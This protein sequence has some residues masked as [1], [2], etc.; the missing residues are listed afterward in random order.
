MKNPLY[1]VC[2]TVMALLYG[3][4]HTKAAAPQ[5]VAGGEYYLYNIHYDRILGQ[6][7]DGT[8]PGLS[9]A[10][11]NSA[12]DSYV[13][14]AETSGTSGYF[15]LRQKSSGKYLAASTANTWS[16]LLQSTRATTDPYLW[17]IIP[18]MDGNL[19]C[20]KAST[21][22]LGCDTG[23]DADAYI[24]VFY[25]KALNEQSRWEVF[26]ANGS[27]DN[28]RKQ[29][30]LEE[31]SRSIA[32]GTLMAQQ[33]TYTE[34]WRQQVSA[35]VTAAEEVYNNAASRT[36][37]QI[38][39]ATSTLRKV[40]ME[41]R[42]SDA[43]TLLSGTNFDVDNSFT[44]ALNGL[45]QKGNN[46][47]ISVLIRNA[48]GMGA[49]IEIDGS[50]GVNIEGKVIAEPTDVEMI[51]HNDY[52]FA[53]NGTTVQIYRDGAL[54]GSAPSY[55]VPAYTANGTGAEW[56]IL[57]ASALNKY[58]P[59]IVSATK[60]VAQG[61]AVTDKYG[62]KTRYAIFLKDQ[63]LE[64]TEAVDFHLMQEATPL[65]NSTINLA[66]ENA[67]LIFDNTLPSVVVNTYL[68]SIKVNG[69][70]AVAGTNVHVGM[71]L[72][73]AIVMPQNSSTIPFTGY[74]GE[75]Y[76]GEATNLKLGANE[77]GKA[78]NSFRSFILKRGYMAVLAS[79]SNGSGYSRVYV[80]DHQDIKV[81]VL[82]QALNQRVSSVHIKK[83][84]YVSKKGWCSDKSSTAAILTDSKAVRA[85]WYY[86]WSADRYSTYDM[87]YIPIKQHL[88]WP[89]QSQ[90]T[91]QTASTHVLGYNEPEHAE[92]HTSSKCSCGGVIS[93]WT[94]CTK[95]PDLQ[96]TGMRIGS[97][98]PTD[99]SWLTQYIGH[100]NDMAYRCDFVVM[101]CYWGTNEAANA[102][103]WY[104]QLKT[105]YN[106]TKRP[107][108][109]T[110]WN[111]GASWTTESWPSSYGD[112]LE[113]NRAAI[114]EIL[115]VLDTCR[116]VER[117]S[118]Y[119]WDSYYRA[120]IADDGWVTPAG[121]VYRDNKSTF[122]YNA[123]VQFTPVWWAPSLKTVELK[124]KINSAAGKLNFTIKN[125]NGDMTDKLIIQRKRADGTYEDY[126]TETDRSVFD[127]TEYTYSF[128]LSDFNTETDEFRLRVTTTAGGETFYSTGLGYIV[129]PNIITS[130]KT[131]VD[132]WTCVKS[133][134]NGF[135]QGTGD[136]FFEVWDTTPADMHF[137]YYQ[138]ITD[139]ASGVYELSAACFNSS[140][141]VAGATVNGHVGLYAQADG[142]EY[143]CPITADA[144][145]N[146]ANRQTLP[147]ILVTNG[148]L[149]IG[150]KNLGAMTARWAGADAFQLRYLGS[151]A[152]ILPQ[153][154]DAFQKE[155]HKESDDRYKALFIW[156][157]EKT[158]ADA[159]P[160]LLNPDCARKDSY[161]WTVNTIDYSTGEAYDADSKNNYWNK[162]ASTAYTSEMYQDLNF[163]PAGDYTASVLLRCSAATTMDF[164]VSRD[165]GLTKEAL[166]TYTGIGATAP[167]GSEY[168]NGWQK[169]TAPKVSLLGGESLRIGFTITATNKWWSAD[170]FTLSYVPALDTS[171]PE[172][173]ASTGCFITAGE[174]GVLVT[175]Q[176]ATDITVYT[177]SGIPVVKRKVD[178]GTTLIPL[179]PGTY[180]VNKQIISL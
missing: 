16:V 10:G 119:N 145:L 26:E 4:L 69:Q 68:A 45:E 159:S 50:S 140:N 71:Y 9:R 52:Q 129:N 11:T 67:W 156:N 60:A 30:Y 155:M 43:L 22:Y 93:P 151:A 31:L 57:S 160:A 49:V 61:T 20:K 142:I 102:A 3:T 58:S 48:K 92:Q 2:L 98:S 64:L 47:S 53:F 162:W 173:S 7:S 29:L 73:G 143:F 27:F 87:E 41:C 72:N 83:W 161:G 147:Q 124:A 114:K 153:G 113:K 178:S 8:T 1:F 112:K 136:T 135:T 89:S 28:S 35:A 149:R 105:I 34:D 179:P 126:Y 95:T 121:Q 172:T 148:T 150:I 56:T 40:L 33:T 39:E 117:Y 82:P 79:G 77:L 97:P 75:L 99:A 177:L 118:I 80:A 174:G 21:Q 96:E 14:V 164:Y 76:A 32:S 109:I 42:A 122:A 130:A 141:A 168:K 139:L 110:E 15:L 108:W 84:N 81:S 25:D 101:H 133:A 134:A 180:V 167:A 59:E 24:S 65:T 62:N 120:M 86:T 55:S 94:S 90:I 106:N 17:T 111:N 152:S 5:I 171:N 78:S 70:K 127:K 23:K 107:I 44:L 176:S 104:N 54:L 157:N 51:H 13:F 37:A 63:T 144:E 175:T 88:Y 12:A 91:G 66:H 6:K 132:G 138:D 128:N 165:G 74:S 115:N 103:A 170:H 85:T 116:F 38:V 163:L 137:D 166:K 131:A 169:V 36:L 125:E 123:D 18:G 46:T 154:A 19:S 158:A 100:C 146:P